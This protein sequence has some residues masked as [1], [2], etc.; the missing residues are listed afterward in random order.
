MAIKILL[1]QPSVEDFFFT[2][3]RSYPLGLLSLATVLRKEGFEASIYNAHER[4]KKYKPL[5]P[6]QFNYLK[7][8]Y[9]PNRSPFCLFS[10]YQ[11]FG[12]SAQTIEQE[13]L[14]RQPQVVGISA[15][16]T[17]Y[18]DSSLETAQ[19]AKRVL[20]QATIVLGGRAVTVNPEL[21]LHDASVDFVLRGEAEFTFL[22]LCR[23]LE[24]GHRPRIDGL[25]YR[26]K[27][28]KLHISRQNALIENLDILP[29]IDHSLINVRNFHFQDDLSVSL[30]AS[31]GCDRGCSFCAIRE[32]LRCRTPELV[33]RE[34][35]NCYALGIR[36][37]NFEDDNINCNP[38][39][40][41]LVDLIIERFD[42]SIRI[43]F[44]N[45]LLSRGLTKRLN[46]RLI[47]AGLTH[48][49]LSM[50]SSQRHFR[51]KLRR[52]EE[53][54]AIFSLATFMADKTIVPTVHYIIGFPGQSFDEAMQDIHVLSQERV[55]LGASIFYP[56]VESKL[57]S[58]EM[59]EQAIA[60]EYPLHRSSA[61]FYDRDISRD[62]IFSLFYFSRVVNFIKQLL[63]KKRID[64]NFRTYLKECLPALLAGDVVGS[65]VSKERLDR[66]VLGM[67]LLRKMVD[68]AHIF[69]AEEK[70]INGK[71]SYAFD[72]E[73][74]VR[75][76]DV[77]KFLE[78]LIV[79]SVSGR[80][81][82][83]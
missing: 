35:E 32:P 57:Y 29:I 77:K 65:V 2:P 66:I 70:R 37:F 75:S 63:D 9:Q 11:R 54:E 6:S 68:E 24:K 55:L 33:L 46:E 58:A 40:E 12:D 1:I 79:C 17:A 69:R 49:D 7:R 34:I 4:N 36:H 61:A 52:S 22:D 18:L 8:Y 44:M 73:I 31:R 67:Y 45:G 20:P 19:I 76:A 30:Y 72:L 48:L 42:S 51:T 81:A 3:Q 56:V 28:G 82:A 23:G 27:Q 10:H 64:R 60:Y 53:P 25:C 41:H 15:N 80:T 39:F 38:H 59:S 21:A 14:R 74:F 83:F 62:R 78:G 47:A 16:F 43:S 71:Y 26:D 5:L 50:V 13:L